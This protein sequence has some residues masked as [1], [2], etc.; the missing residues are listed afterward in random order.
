MCVIFVCVCVCA[1]CV[2]FVCA[3]CDLCV[4]EC[5]LVCMCM[6]VFVC[7]FVCVYE[8]DDSF[9]CAFLNVQMSNQNVDQFWLNLFLR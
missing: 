6:C 7:V 8:L 5:V 2:V 3:V 9:H 4:C 1:L